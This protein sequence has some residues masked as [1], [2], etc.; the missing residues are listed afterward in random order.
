MKFKYLIFNKLIRVF[1]I[2]VAV[3]YFV[4]FFLS[5]EQ[6]IG[7]N[8]KIPTTIPDTLKNLTDEELLHRN[9]NY[10]SDTIL[11]IIYLRSYLK[12]AIESFDSIKVARAYFRLNFYENDDKI[13]LSYIDSSISIS[14]DL[15]NKEY[16]LLAYSSKAGF[17][18][19][20][21]DYEKALKYYLIT[22]KYSKKYKADNFTF[23]TKYNIALIKSRIGK[24]LE[25]LNT[26]KESLKFEHKKGIKDTLDYISILRDI[27]EI[28]L[29]LSKLDSAN[30]YI[31]NAKNLL[32][33][34]KNSTFYARIQLLEAISLYY[35]REYDKSINLINEILERISLYEDKTDLVKAYTY[36][37][38]NSNKIADEKT[39][40]K[41]YVKVDSIFMTS[42]VAIPEM[43]DSYIYLIN[44]YKSN[45][46]LDKQL[47]KVEKL[48]LFD[49]IIANRK[50]KISNQLYEDFDTPQFLEQKNRIID[51]IERR[52]FFYKIILPFLIIILLILYYLFYSNFRK[53]KIYYQR[54]TELLKEKN[55]ENANPALK[56]KE[57]I[58]SKL[59]I[60]PKKVREISEKLKCFEE[61]KQYLKSNITTN[62]LA[63]DFKT[64][65]KYL[66]KIILRE[67]DKKFVDYINDLRVDYAVEK[68]K[69]NKLFNNYSIK[70]IANDVGFNSAES[71]SKAFYKR[72]K[73]YPSYFIK[74]NK[75]ILNID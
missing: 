19:N 17:Y 50:L 63:K 33:L 20:R 6:V 11:S 35:S 10:Y 24:P 62:S 13:K 73:I 30:R 44:H 12:R 53:K 58:D 57:K 31:R 49:S 5:C 66:S 8:T 21:W 34:K 65:T 69:T 16:P 47:E 38:N 23:L 28:Y 22:L 37:G 7:Q 67:Y 29:N 52:N 72:N 48:L 1:L 43:R 59:H 68:L 46:N 54:F 14:K 41:N 60:S 42:G 55:K 64:N 45:R 40:F 51:K 70:S 71:F 36:L 27:S 2:E 75:K 56:I 61:N 32:V 74:Q 39:A 26:F 18:F 9:E 25:A 3:S 4:I 15:K